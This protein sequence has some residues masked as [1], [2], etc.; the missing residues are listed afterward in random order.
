[1][2][3]SGGLQ[4][5]W[6]YWNFKFNS[7]PTLFPKRVYNSFGGYYN[8]KETVWGSLE[9]SHPANFTCPGVELRAFTIFQGT[10]VQS[11]LQKSEIWRGKA[12]TFDKQAASSGKMT[13]VCCSFQSLF[14]CHAGNVSKGPRTGSRSDQRIG[15]FVVSAETVA[16]AT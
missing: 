7:L 3:V 1:M 10:W 9:S 4:M 11:I 15:A 6:E 8:Q 16:A 13:L 14:L 2:V 5:N 12:L